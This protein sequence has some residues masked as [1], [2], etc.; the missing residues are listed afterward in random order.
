MRFRGAIGYANQ[1]ETSPGVWT[2]VITER[3]Y[4][5]DVTQASRRL[6]DA[7]LSLQTVNQD[8]TLQ[9]SIAI[10]ADAFA[11]ENFV[12]MRYVNWNGKNW[13]ITDVQIRRP[14]M[15]LSIGGL[16]NGDTP[17]APSGT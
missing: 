4:T 12:D 6:T 15:I 17:G 8:I 1:Q 2:D 3:T 5:G 16:W 9:N 14:R 11:V 10:V 7:E 13:I